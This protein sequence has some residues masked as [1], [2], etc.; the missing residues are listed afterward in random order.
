ML[1]VIM[2]SKFYNNNNT[3]FHRFT[4]GPDTVRVGVVQYATHP[5]TEFTMNDNQNITSLA[6][7]IDGINW[8]KGDTHTAEALR[9]L[10]ILIR[11]S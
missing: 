9:C 5:K 7:A 10:L 8:M 11:H 4:I 2:S 1:A 3:M 6:E